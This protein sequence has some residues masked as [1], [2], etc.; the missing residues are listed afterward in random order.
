MRRPTLAALRPAPAHALVPLH[1]KSGPTLR[2]P[3]SRTDRRL[4]CDSARRVRRGGWVCQRPVPTRGR[5]GAGVPL[6][7]PLPPIAARRP[8]RRP[9]PAEQPGRPIVAPLFV[10]LFPRPPARIAPVP[11]PLAPGCRAVRSCAVAPPA[12]VRTRLL[13]VPPPAPR[14]LAVRRR[15]PPR[16]V[17]LAEQRVLQRRV[18][19]GGDQDAATPAARRRARQE[20]LGAHGPA[21]PAARAD[22]RARRI[23]QARLDAGRRRPVRPR[24]SR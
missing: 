17:L 11:L 20:V 14:L 5:P 4:P 24:R 7:V 21:R 8:H 15:T 23:D 12:G 3:R 9:G 16:D 1:R 18:G 13:P 22:D 6:G 19:H 10:P 2:P